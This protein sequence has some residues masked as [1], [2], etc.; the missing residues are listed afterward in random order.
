MLYNFEHAR[1]EFTPF[2]VAPHL[3]DFYT[4]SND[5]AKINSTKI[6]PKLGI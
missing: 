5:R 3:E 4:P 1:K 6:S 2:T